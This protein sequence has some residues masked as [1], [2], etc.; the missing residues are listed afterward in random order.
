M[1]NKVDKNEFICNWTLL[2]CDILK[3]IY[4][5][6]TKNKDKY[7]SDVDMRKAVR[8]HLNI[9]FKDKLSDF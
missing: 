1:L 2:Q 5:F 4:S 7:L 9:K 8:T 6:K 3:E